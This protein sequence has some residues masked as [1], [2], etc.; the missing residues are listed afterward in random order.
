MTGHTL[1]LAQQLLGFD[2]INPPGDEAACMAFFAGWL[3][4]QGFDVTLSGFGE[5][6]VNLIAKMP[7]SQPGK[8]LAFTGHLDNVPLG[9]Q[10]WQH[11]PFGS[12]V[13]AEKLYGRGASDMKAAVAAFAVACVT[14][15]TPI[16]AGKGVVMIITGGE[17]TGCDGAKALIDAGML[18][19]VGALIVGEPTANYP[20]IG[21]KVRYGC[22]AKRAVKPP[23]ARCRSWGLTLFISPLKRW[24]KFSIS[25]R[26]RRTR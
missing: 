20:V 12:D 2:T 22:A 16:R 21:H 14:H 15:Q 13:T 11:D 23:T 8:P 4:T 6:R 5:K 7:G 9:N 1:A 10:T 24:E 3:E 18:P 25:N 19:P 17:E 26:A